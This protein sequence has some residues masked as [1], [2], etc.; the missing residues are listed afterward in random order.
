MPTPINTAQ[1]A[2]TRGIPDPDHPGRW[3][4]WPWPVQASF[5]D[6]VRHFLRA[7][8]PGLLAER[9]VARQLAYFEGYAAALA[10]APTHELTYAADW[11]WHDELAGCIGDCVAIFRERAAAAG[12]ETQGN[13]RVLPAGVRAVR[14]VP[15]THGRV[16]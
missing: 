5:C 15:L 13:V 16:S 14:P 10:V 2:L 11:Q 9:G 4:V 7:Y 1:A 6:V 3:L 8:V 12:L